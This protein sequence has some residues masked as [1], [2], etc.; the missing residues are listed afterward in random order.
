MKFKRD[1]WFAV[2]VGLLFLSMGMLCSASTFRVGK[3]NTSCPNAQYTTITD[4]INAASSGD[5]I[6]ICPA[7][8]PEQLVITKS[9]VLRG[10][11]THV[12][13]QFLP[14][15]NLVDRVLLQPALQDLQALPFESVIT[16]MNTEGVTID[17][18]AIDASQNTVASCDVAL[19]AVH[20]YNASGRLS[21]SA[22]SGAHLS[23]PQNCAT[24]FGNGFGVAVDSD[25]GGSHHVEIEEN[26]IH[27]FQRDGVEVNGAGVSVEIESNNVSG[28][29]PAGG[30]NQFG[31]F[32]LNGAVG[33]V[34][35]NVITEGPCGSLSISDCV[36]LRSEGVVLRTAGDGTVVDHNVINHV[37][38]GIFLNTVNK[39]RVSNNLIGNID[40]LDGVDMTNTSNSVI[41]SNTIFNATPLSNLSE[42]IFEAFGGTEGNNL[43][44][45][46]T[47]NDAYCGIAFVATSQ[48][49]HGRYSN[50]LYPE[51]LSN[52]VSGPPP[53]EPPLP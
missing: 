4:A 14:C 5:V 1:L 30:V 36:S 31:I 21:G 35:G 17:N 44:V 52:G 19:S 23:N 16:I 27:D 15:C 20:F 37:Q 9:L 34:V 6:E 11:P 7:L 47:V 41:D 3:A 49:K 12:L 46:N 28:I 42:G 32:L 29:G 51:L 38:S 43:I 24:F 40:A 33:Q 50:V 25:D 26:S 48:V 18:L 22:V 53:T 39:I 45:D 10:I 2:S 8:Y 13:T